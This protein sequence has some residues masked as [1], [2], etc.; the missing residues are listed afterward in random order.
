MSRPYIGKRIDFALPLDLLA[1]VEAIADARGVK[2][3]EVLREAVE[4]YVRRR[5]VAR[6]QEKP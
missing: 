3:A 1:R 2:R 5:K 6:N 4:Q